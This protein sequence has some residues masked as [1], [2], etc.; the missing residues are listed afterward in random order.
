M[1]YG[2]TLRGVLSNYAEDYGILFVYG[3]SNF[4]CSLYLFCFVKYFMPIKLKTIKKENLFIPSQKSLTKKILTPGL[5]CLTYQF[6]V[7]N[8]LRP[9][10]RFYLIPNPASTCYIRYTIC[11]FVHV[12]LDVLTEFVYFC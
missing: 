9:Y 11:S 3:L 7:A 5:H 6:S 4:T 8:I 12:V 10:H 1:C 2:N